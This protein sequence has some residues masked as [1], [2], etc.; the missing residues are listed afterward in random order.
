MKAY[1]PGIARIGESIIPRLISH[2]GI[3]FL[4]LLEPLDSL[5]VSCSLCILQ[6]HLAFSRQESSAVS[7]KRISL[8]AHAL[9]EDALCSHCEKLLYNVQ[10]VPTFKSPVCQIQKITRW[11]GNYG[12]ASLHVL[13][14]LYFYRLLFFKFTVFKKEYN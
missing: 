5:S 6:P 10:Y 2:A 9:R 4:L 3:L 7:L 8:S 12:E 13:E 11:T 14:Q 1:G